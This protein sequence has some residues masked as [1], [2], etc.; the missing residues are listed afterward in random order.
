MFNKI[1]LTLEEHVNAPLGCGCMDIGT[2]VQHI[3]IICTEE[4]FSGTV[5]MF[6][7]KLKRK[8]NHAVQM[9]MFIYVLQSN[10]H[11]L[12]LYLV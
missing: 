10:N 3:P 12:Y 1:K 7:L 8:K 5:R 9:L 2:K 4:E 11:R 6:F